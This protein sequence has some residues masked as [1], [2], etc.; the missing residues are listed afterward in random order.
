[1]YLYSSA[2]AAAR[3]VCSA[4]GLTC[5]PEVMI[6]EPVPRPA[7]PRADGGLF[8]W[9][10]GE[11]VVP[12]DM[13]PFSSAVRRAVLVPGGTCVYC[14]RGQLRDAEWWEVDHRLPRARGGLSVASNAALA[15]STCNREK[16]ANL[17][18]PGQWARRRGTASATVL[19]FAA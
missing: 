1:M 16:G 14:E 5:E 13:R 2:I 15:C 12:I 6:G 11:L 7:V 4:H 8:G 19:L 17:W 18:R 9:A 10:G 3:S